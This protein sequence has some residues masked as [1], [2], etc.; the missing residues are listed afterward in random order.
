[1]IL[2]AWRR[3]VI[4]RLFINIKL[5]GGVWQNALARNYR[6]AHQLGFGE[7]NSKGLEM[8]QLERLEI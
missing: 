7:K 4:S 2:G 1:M 5:H 8:N 6:L 3:E